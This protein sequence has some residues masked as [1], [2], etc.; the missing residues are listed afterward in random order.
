[1]PFRKSGVRLPKCTLQQSEVKLVIRLKLGRFTHTLRLRQMRS[2]FASFFGR[3]AVRLALIVSGVG[4]VSCSDPYSDKAIYENTDQPFAVAAL[5]GSDPTAP[6]GL[7]LSTRS[8]VRIDGAF[9]FDLAFDINAAGKIVVMPVGRVGTPLTGTRAIG[10]YRSPTHYA[11]LKEAPK[12]GYFFDSTMAITKGGETVI[13]L[14]QQT[15]CTYSLSPTTYAKI[16]I[17]S[18]SVNRMIYGRAVINLNCG[19]RQLTTGLPSF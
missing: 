16:A 7:Q 6:A 17:E 13:I 18:V 5:T 10:L 11:D 12:S 8:V 9:D 3:P 2:S 15:S 19:K 1:M 4:A 14:S